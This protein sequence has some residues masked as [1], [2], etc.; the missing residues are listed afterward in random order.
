[1]DTIT[2]DQGNVYE[3]VKWYLPNEYVLQKS[4]QSSE[5]QEE[6][7]PCSESEKQDF[8]D[9]KMLEKLN[10]DLLHNYKNTSWCETQFIAEK[11]KIYEKYLLD[12]LMNNRDNKRDFWEAIEIIQYLC[13]YINWLQELASNHAPSQVERKKSRFTRKYQRLLSI[14][15]SK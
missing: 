6:S 7:K 1:M 13:D 10:N 5:V 12:R 4:S 8:W 3:I 2:S 14:L 11:H 15:S 9:Y